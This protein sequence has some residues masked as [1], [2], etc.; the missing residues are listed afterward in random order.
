MC[1]RVVEV[2]TQKD[3]SNRVEEGL[4]ELHYASFDDKNRELMVITIWQED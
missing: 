3:K 1:E 2:L 4:R